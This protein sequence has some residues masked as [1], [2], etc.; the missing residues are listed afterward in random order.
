MGLGYGKPLVM[1]D[2][3]L[4]LFYSFIYFRLTYY[5]QLNINLIF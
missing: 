2:R 3:G 4:Q 5:E 1:N